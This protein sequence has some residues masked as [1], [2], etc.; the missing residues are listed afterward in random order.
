MGLHETFNIN[1]L[2]IDF[3][4]PNTLS[5]ENYVEVIRYLFSDSNTEPKSN[6]FYKK[7]SESSYFTIFYDLKENQVMLDFLQKLF[8]LNKENIKKGTQKELE[9]FFEHKKRHS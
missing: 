1:G 4:K 8:L 2:S 5:E 3:S 6:F 9:F 7:I